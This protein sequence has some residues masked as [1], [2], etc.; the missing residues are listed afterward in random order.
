M[1]DTIEVRGL[2]VVA[3]CGVDDEERRSLQPL[4]VDLDVELDAGRAGAS[5]DLDDTVS[6]A[7]VCEVA[8]AAIIDAAPRLVE[9]ASEV[10]GRAVLALDDRIDAVTVAVTKLRPPIP[11]DVATAGVRRRLAR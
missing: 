11:L 6:Y 1:P 9:H 10:A 4:T 8:A 5:D 7:L 3:I 2:R